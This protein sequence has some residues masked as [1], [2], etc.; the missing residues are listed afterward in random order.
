MDQRGFVRE[1]LWADKQAEKVTLEGFP[2]Q[3]KAVQNEQLNGSI[4]LPLVWKLT[5][6]R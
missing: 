3:C 2:K 4:V 5:V 1:R 6:E